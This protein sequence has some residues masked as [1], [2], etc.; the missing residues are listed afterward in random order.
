MTDLTSSFLLLFPGTM[1]LHSQRPD[2]RQPD[3]APAVQRC[4]QARCR[5]AAEGRRPASAKE[6][7][8]ARRLG[9][10]V[11][12]A[13]PRQ[14]PAAVPRDHQAQPGPVLVRHRASPCVLSIDP[15]PQPCLRCYY[16]NQ[17]QPPFLCL[18]SASGAEVKP[19]DSL[20]GFGAKHN[21]DVALS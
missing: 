3:D 6:P 2:T 12:G 8:A 9:G 10:G 16:H 4:H 19:D 14:D 1:R 13:L 5:P 15:Q 21:S 18:E 11:P 20:R 17:S 7:I